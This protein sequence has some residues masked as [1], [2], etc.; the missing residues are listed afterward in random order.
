MDLL[1]C[2]CS[3]NMHVQEHV[4]S[5]IDAAR[6]TIPHVLLEVVLP[7]EHLVLLAARADTACVNTVRMLYAM[8]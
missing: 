1:V 4:P 6:M 2:Q 5:T 7:L 3:L 8:P